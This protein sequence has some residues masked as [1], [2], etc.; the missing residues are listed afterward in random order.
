MVL[1]SASPVNDDMN[2]LAA[3]IDGDC[4]KFMVFVADSFFS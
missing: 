2:E 1:S 3:E 4:E